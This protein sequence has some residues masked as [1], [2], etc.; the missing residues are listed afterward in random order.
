MISAHPLERRRV[1]F[2]D[3]D[4]L[5]EIKADGFRGLLYVADQAGCFVS[6]NG[7]EMRRFGEW[8]LARIQGQDKADKSGPAKGCVGDSVNS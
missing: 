6:R 3:P 7:R 5:F 2:D 1:P 8:A 4:W